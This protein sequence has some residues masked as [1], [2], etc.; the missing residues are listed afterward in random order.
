MTGDV[1]L[2]GQIRFSP[3]ARLSK[4]EV[5]MAC[6]LLASAE[7]LARAQGSLETAAELDALIGLLEE[8]LAVVVDHVSDGKG[9][10]SVQAGHFATL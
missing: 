9:G 6:D 4:V 8:R 10:G 5:F 1:G 7:V 3:S 2:V